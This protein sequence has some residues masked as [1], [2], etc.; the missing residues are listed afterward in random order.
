MSSAKKLFF[1]ISLIFLIAC[2][3]IDYQDCNGIVNGGA[4]YDDCGVCVGGRTGLTECIVDCNGQLGGSAFLNQCELCVEGNTDIPE[5]S[6]SNLNFN[7]YS[8]NTVIIG[9]QVWLAEDLKTDQFSDGS[10]IPNYN[11]EVNNSSGS[12]FVTNSEDS[13][14]SRFYYSAKTLNQL[15]PIGW[16]IP[17]KA[18]V[19]NL[20][21]ELGGDNIAGGKLK[22]AGYN[23]WDFPN[24]FATDEVGFAALGTGY[25]NNSGNLVDAQKRYSFW[26][27]DT[28]RVIDSIETYYWTLKLSFDSNN[29]LLVPDSSRLGHPVRLIKD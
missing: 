18:D 14:N 22:E 20:I 17:T 29:A 27:Q 5:D 9:H 7:G 23:S 8:Y 25:R 24:Q 4:Y 12:K 28:L 6:C 3:D 16:R 26:T 1:T 15:A 11:S 2:E 13:E 19:E 21:N 10:T